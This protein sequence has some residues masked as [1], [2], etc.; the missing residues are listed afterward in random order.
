VATTARTTLVGRPGSVG[1][2]VGRLLWLP[3]SSSPVTGVVAGLAAE[4]TLG[5][6][7]AAERARLQAALEAAGAELASLAR[8]TASRAGDE[9]G[10]IFEA[11]ALFA[12]DPGII[13]PAMAAI[14]AG[15]DAAVA[16][17]RVTADQAD[18]LAG[19]DD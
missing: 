4:A 10:A 1:V 17:D 13:E 12:A 7:P 3:P 9:I 14:D 15:A 16:I 6:D 2:G 11:Q 19:V 5:Y 18:K 8:E